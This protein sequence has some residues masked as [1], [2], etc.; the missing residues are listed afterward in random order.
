MEEK[1]R[2]KKRI[3]LNVKG[4]IKRELLKRDFKMTLNNQRKSM[5]I[6]FSIDILN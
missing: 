2:S 6:V 4:V 3:K 1:S 5:S